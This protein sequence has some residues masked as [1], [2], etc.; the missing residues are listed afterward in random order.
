MVSAPALRVGA[1]SLLFFPRAPCPARP[2]CRLRTERY[3]NLGWRQFKSLA[4]TES[5]HSRAS[6]EH[7]LVM[8]LRALLR[9]SCNWNSTWEFL[10]SRVTIFTHALEKDSHMRKTCIWIL[11]ARVRLFR[12]AHWAHICHKINSHLILQPLK[13]AISRNCKLHTSF[14]AVSDSFLSGFKW[15]ICSYPSQG[16]GMAVD[17]RN[18]FMTFQG[19][20]ERIR[21]CT[22]IGFCI[23]CKNPEKQKLE[24]RWPCLPEISG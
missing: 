1:P 6:L 2:F 9:H 12:T 18:C 13:G 8:L 14:V 10:R 4:A 7:Q 19:N 24:N 23:S 11:V 17:C 22:N 21:C 3:F 5:E 16:F 20:L 15:W